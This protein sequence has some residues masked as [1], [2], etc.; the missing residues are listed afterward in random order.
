MTEFSPEKPNGVLYDARGRVVLRFGEFDVGEWYAV[1]DHIDPFHGIDY[2]DSPTPGAAL[3]KPIEADPNRDDLP[4]PTPPDA[5]NARPK[6]D[7]D[8]PQAG[9][10]KNA[11][12]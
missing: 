11:K 6:H 8:N 10:F 3:G 4:N 2:S 1:A 7:V 12:R 9:R 5:P